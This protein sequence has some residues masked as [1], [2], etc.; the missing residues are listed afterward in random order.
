[1]TGGQDPQGQL[2]VPEVVQLVLLE[3]V[4]RVI[5]TTED[6]D[7]L[8]Q[9]RVRP[10]T[11]TASRCGDRG[12]LIEAQEV[13]ANVARR[14]GAGARPGVRRREPR[15]TQPR[16][17]WPSPASGSSST[18]GCARAAATAATRATA[19]RC[20]RSTRRTG[21]RRRIHQTSCNYD[22]SC[23][24][25]RLP[26]VRHR[27]R[28]TTTAAS[29]RAEVDPPSSTIPPPGCPSRV[30]VVDRRVHCAPVGHRRHRRDHRQPDPRHGGDARRATTCAVSTRPGCRRRR[31]RWRATSACRRGTAAGV[32]PRRG[33]RCRLMLAFDMLAAASDHHRERRRT[34]PHGG[35]SDRSRSCRPGAWSPTRTAPSTPLTE[36]SPRSARRRVATRAQPLPRLG[37]DLQ[38][39]VREHDRRQRADARRR[40]AGRRA[41]DR[42]RQPGAGDR[43]QRRR[44][45]AE[46][47]RLPV[48]AP[49]GGRPGLDREARPVSR[50][51]R[52]R[53]STS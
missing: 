20:S 45:P 46:H 18:S 31:D 43:A 40:C 14:H 24:T 41:A 27:H 15:R 13:L 47:R 26:G 21:A 52:P 19:C 53:R 4:E 36:R 17:G 3:G 30:P 42:S 23:L 12:R 44:R 28:R 37:G 16:H 48:R 38:G 11:A 34:R 33:R 9:R 51:A 32:E 49:V 5:V 35:R 6:P 1:M 10:S 8:R 50:C 7:T 25:R 39:A 29:P 2:T 22:M